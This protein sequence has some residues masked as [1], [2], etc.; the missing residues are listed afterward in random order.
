M[1]STDSVTRGAKWWFVVGYDN[2]DTTAWSGDSFTINLASTRTDSKSSLIK[3]TTVAP[4]SSGEIELTIDCSGCEAASHYTIALSEGYH[5]LDY[6]NILFYTGVKGTASYSEIVIGTTV[7]SGD[8]A[9]NTSNRGL[10]VATVTIK[11]EWPVNLA[12][13]ENEFMGNQYTYICDINAYQ[14]I[15]S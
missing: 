3:N 9:E 11:W 13:N 4:G 8:I 12:V 7:L 14:I 10:Q 1:I 15:A 6:P 2:N 5:Q